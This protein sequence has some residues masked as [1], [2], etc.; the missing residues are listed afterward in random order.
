MVLDHVADDAVFIEITRARA[1]PDIF[2]P[3]DLHLLD[4]APVPER[5][6]NRVGESKHQQVLDDLFAEIVINAVDVPLG[7][8]LRQLARHAVG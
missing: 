7:E 8:R 5:F 4:A 6:E 3:R 1:D 2:F